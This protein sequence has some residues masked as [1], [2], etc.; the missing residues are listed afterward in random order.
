MLRIV[1]LLHFSFAKLKTLARPWKFQLFCFHMLF[2]LFEHLIHY[3]F[4]LMFVVASAICR[5]LS[6][7]CVGFC[8]MALLVWKHLLIL[9]KW[10]SQ[11]NNMKLYL[12]IRRTPYDMLLVNNFC[13]QEY[14]SYAS[15]GCEAAPPGRGLPN[16]GIFN[17]QSAASF[18]LKKKSH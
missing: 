17:F 10:S 9:K 1:W 2:M 11:I 16:F 14:V 3:E 18:L 6:G 4:S 7:E 5:I 8:A 15:S 13:I 12:N